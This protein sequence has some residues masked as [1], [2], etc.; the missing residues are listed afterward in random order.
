MKT[1]VLRD[2][3]AGTSTNVEAI[4]AFLKLD[5]V[6]SNNERA[7]VSF[8]GV[9]SMSSSFLNSLFGEL[10]DKYGYERVINSF[11]LKNCTKFNARLLKDYLVNYKTY[12]H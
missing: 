9:N 7:I 2:L 11:E 3:V 6:I 8:I 4:P 1:I 5:N 10:I 12:I